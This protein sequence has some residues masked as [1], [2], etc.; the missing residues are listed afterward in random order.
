MGS[1]SSTK[2]S[3]GEE[4]QSPVDQNPTKTKSYNLKSITDLTYLN[5]RQPNFYLKMNW[6]LKNG[7]VV[8]DRIPAFVDYNSWPG[9]VLQS[10]EAK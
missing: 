9:P 5:D 10:R 4:R 2:N 6:L 3:K 7:V 1:T 8:I